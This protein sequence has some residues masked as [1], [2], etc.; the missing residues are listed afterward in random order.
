MCHAIGQMHEQSRSDRDNYVTM[1]WQNIRGGRGNNNMAKSSTLDNN[2]YDYE[3]VLQYGLYSF[4][5]N[6]RPSMEL[7]DR[8]LDFLA[9]SATGLMF[10][11]VQDVIDAYQCTTCGRDQILVAP[12]LSATI[13]TPNYPNNYPLNIQCVW[14]VKAPV[15][16][17]VK[18]TIDDLNLSD[19]GNAC[20][21]WLEIQYNLLG[22]TGPRRCGV[23]K[24]ITYR[25]T[26][27]G[28]SNIMLLKFDSAFAADRPAGKG[29]KLSL[30]AVGP[31]CSTNPCMFGN[32]MEAD[33]GSYTCNCDSGWQGRNCD[34]PDGSLTLTCGFE[35]GSVCF[36]DNM[37]GDDFDWTIH[38]GP[39]P[40]KNTGPSAAKDGI[41]YLYTEMSSPQK[42][43]D[44]ARYETMVNLQE[45]SDRCLGLWFYMYGS[46]VGTLNI[47]TYTA[48]ITSKQILWTKSKEQGQAWL[49]AAVTIPI[50][51]GVKVYY[52]MP[53]FRIYYSHC[54]GSVDSGS[55]VTVGYI[56]AIP[57]V[58]IG[59]EMVGGPSWS[60]DV[61]I[62]SVSLSPGPCTNIPPTP[63]MAP[64]TTKRSTT[65]RST[66]S[67][68]TC[69]TT[70]F[71]TTPIQDPCNSRPCFNG[72]TCMSRPGSNTFWCQCAPMYTGLQCEISV[73]TISPDPCFSQPCLNNGTCNRSPGALT[74]WCTCSYPWTGPI[75]ETPIVPNGC[76]THRCQNNAT[77][78]SDSTFPDGYYCA[79]DIGWSGLYCQ[80]PI[81]TDPCIPN[82][83]MNNG[84]CYSDPN[85]LTGSSCL[86]PPD[87]SG[88]YCEMPTTN[89]THICN[90]NPCMNNGTCY[91]DPVST[92]GF[93]C[94]CQSGWSGLYCE[95]PIT[96]DPCIPNP[97]INNGSCYSDPNSLTGSSCLCPPD[98]SG[99]YCE[100]PTTNTTHVCNP[101]P[102]MNN[103]TCYTD[104]VSTVGFSCHCLP[105]WSGL[106]CE[107]PLNPGKCFSS[108]CLNNGTCY[109]DPNSQNGHYCVC[110]HGWTGTYCEIPVT[111][112][113]C[114][115]NACMNGGTCYDDPQNG[116]FCVCS[117][118]WTGLYCEIPV[119]T[120]SCFSNACM[121][122]GTCYDDSNSL[123]GYY[124]YCPHGWTGIHCEFPIAPVQCLSNTCMNNGTCFDDQNSLN[125]YYCHCTPGWTGFNCEIAVTTGLC[126]SN[127]CLNNGTCY[128]DPNSPNGNY[129]CICTHAWTGSH[130]EIPMTPTDPCYYNPCVNNVTCRADATRA[131]GFVCLCLPG[132]SGLYCELSQIGS[133]ALHA[134]M[135]NAT[136]YNDT[137]YSPSGYYCS[138]TIGW[139]GSYCEIPMT[140]CQ[141]NAC[142][143]N[144]TCYDDQYSITGYYCHCGPSW[145][146]IHYYLCLHFMYSMYGS[147]MGE[148]SVEQESA[149]FPNPVFS[150]SGNQGE[151]WHQAVAEL[152]PLKNSK[153][154]IFGI[155]GTRYTSDIAIDDIH[156][157]TG[158]CL[159]ASNPCQSGGICTPDPGS[160][161]GYYCSCPPEYTSADCSVL[162]D[163]NMHCGFEQDT[164]QFH[165][166]TYDDFDWTRK[167]GRTRTS[168]TGPGRASNGEYY[169]YIE[170]SN[171]K[172]GEKAILESY[173]KIMGSNCVVMEYHMFG[174]NVGELNISISNDTSGPIALWTRK[175]SLG[176]SWKT[177][178]VQI[179]SP[180]PY[181]VRIL[182]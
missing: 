61:A 158:K 153:L 182:P 67:T 160:T 134:C 172:K 97:C 80:I 146:G 105:G 103:G 31:G 144:G 131:N 113:L 2:P 124:C 173:S 163:S 84:S 150:M 81:T 46:A 3:S 30:Q 91:T 51:P 41:N 16:M 118:A 164:C 130:C 108:A 152:I 48:S 19:N 177:G 122:G 119:T 101:N 68:T 29:F 88:F 63:T 35:P 99:F 112:G 56:P 167:S 181:R 42:D 74:F 47:Y 178:A 33:G 120:G 140:T 7:T 77:C 109:D 11:D 22:Q 155:R 86:C 116:Y 137:L 69:S 18:M 141:S 65:T 49:Q 89:T 127:A 175:G 165:Q 12:G 156:L 27:D 23:V 115:S 117:H 17:F 102:C 151:G 9:D 5:S 168:G 38:S 94:Y 53:G 14:I 72:A 83:C 71:V 10:Y 64:S 123:N 75:C 169:L 73:T 34:T 174:K 135:N 55:R 132:W 139:S 58:K 54:I 24:G 133:C 66:P 121:N 157:D 129:Y 128:D 145:T 15:G 44:T 106:Y 138:C 176:N 4:S 161:L 90:P 26:K 21:H 50:I 142:M 32:C 125:G 6:G 92:V 85:S 143:N 148:L 100:M 149:D 13:Q 114:F 104:P 154:K 28:N 76:Y 107:M 179:N 98:W 136:C 70:P 36:M 60:A 40:S 78:Y 59:F 25:T 57:G 43:G 95:M 62:D 159:C 79:C 180:T 8:R 166:S 93:S 111:T 37:D 147:G 52:I 110:M 45:T 126:F 39:T 170:S 1:L 96:T 87:W 162:I 82:P 20:Y 171:R